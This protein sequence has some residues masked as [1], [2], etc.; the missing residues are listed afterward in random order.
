MSDLQ[1]KI[2]KA[3]HELA[4]E[5]MEKRGRGLDDRYGLAYEGGKVKRAHH[6]KGKALRSRSRSIGRGE[7][8]L[9]HRSR[10]RSMGRMEPRHRSRSRSMG[11]M[12]PRHRSRSRSMGRMEPRHR[13]RSRS[14]GRG[15]SDRYGLA[16]EGGI[17]AY[18]MRKPKTTRKPSA[19]NLFVK[20]V[21]AKHPGTPFK[22]IGMMWRDHK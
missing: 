18:G 19:Y 5:E 9:R 15:L 20:K 16:Y 8:L 1:A 4:M 14:M 11:R 21:L 2:K 6:K 22:E 10:S 12:E 3:A 13:S 17:F 7:A